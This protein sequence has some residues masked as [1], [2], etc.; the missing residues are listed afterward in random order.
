[1]QSATGD[2]GRSVWAPGR[3]TQAGLGGRQIEWIEAF[4]LEL[5]DSVRLFFVADDPQLL[6]LAQH[7]PEQ[8]IEWMRLDS[9]VSLY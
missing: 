3:D 2:H 8:S 4:Y 5:V 7:L 6:P 9:Y 1:V